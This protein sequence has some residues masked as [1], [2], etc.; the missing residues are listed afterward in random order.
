MQQLKKS[1]RR[2]EILIKFVLLPTLIIGVILFL[3]RHQIF[4]RELTPEEIRA[5]QEN[6]DQMMLKSIESSEK[7]SLEKSQEEKAKGDCIKTAISNGEV[8]ETYLQKCAN[9]SSERQR[10]KYGSGVSN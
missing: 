1:A 10:E 6:F 4:D 2:K 3:F 9:E 7:A 5:S 8:A